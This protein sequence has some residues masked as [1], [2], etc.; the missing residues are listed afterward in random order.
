[1]DFQTLFLNLY[2]Q[3]EEVIYRTDDDVD[4]SRAACLRPQV[5]LKIVIVTLAKQLQETEEV[6]GKLVVCHDFLI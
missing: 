2:L 5:V 4:G 6:T 3:S 1:M